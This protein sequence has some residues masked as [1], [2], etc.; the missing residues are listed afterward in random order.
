MWCIN[1]TG[2]QQPL[3]ICSVSFSTFSLLVELA[4]LHLHFHHFIFYHLITECLMKHC[5]MC[6][7]IHWKLLINMGTGKHFERHLIQRA[8]CG[9]FD[10]VIILCFKATYI[11]NLITQSAFQTGNWHSRPCA[12]RKCYKYAIKHVCDRAWVSS[13]DWESVLN[14]FDSTAF[15]ALATGAVRQGAWCRGM[16]ESDGCVFWVQGRIKGRSG[17]GGEWDRQRSLAII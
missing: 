10:L 13:T 7:L 3:Q 8:C 14:H 4:G 16:G 11:P 12:R 5:W 9:Y 1:A 15:E 2:T 6:K 17:P